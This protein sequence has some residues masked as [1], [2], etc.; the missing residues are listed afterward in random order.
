MTG[1]VHEHDK[2]A[3]DN[4]ALAII[5]EQ[6]PGQ[7]S[8]IMS[9]EDY[10]GKFGN[11]ISGAGADIQNHQFNISSRLTSKSPSKGQAQQ[12]NQAGVRSQGQDSSQV[13]QTSGPV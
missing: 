9:N 1:Q 13:S 3:N 5:E 8:E 11:G 4:A 12:Q 7:Q 2:Q 6:S 10:D